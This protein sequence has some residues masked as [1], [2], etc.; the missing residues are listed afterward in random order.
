MFNVIFYSFFRRTNSKWEPLQGNNLKK[1]AD[2][3]KM[4]SVDLEAVNLIKKHSGGLKNRSVLDLNGGSGNYSNLFL[5]MGSQVL[6]TDISKKMIAIAKR[7]LKNTRRIEYK[8]INPNKINKLE[9]S[10]DLIFFRLSWRYCFNDKAFAKKINSK[11]NPGGLVYILTNNLVYKHE[12]KSFLEKLQT[13]IYKYLGM[14]LGHPNPKK[15]LIPRLFKKYKLEMIH[16][17]DTETNEE[18]IFKKND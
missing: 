8:Q 5:E 11:L 9:E 16:Y 2:S 14:K 18:M 15:N 6:Y 17:L 13:H 10:F 4:D 3:S 12:E 1:Y 7:N